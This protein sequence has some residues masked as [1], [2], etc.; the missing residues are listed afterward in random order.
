MILKSVTRNVARE[1]S[2]LWGMDDLEAAWIDVHDANLSLRWNVERP[3]YEERRR[4][5]W[6]QFAFDPLE[7][8]RVGRRSHSLSAGGDSEVECVREMARHLAS[9]KRRVAA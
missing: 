6:Q 2:R 9:L 1:M 8:P 4:P 5:P 3:R 7:T